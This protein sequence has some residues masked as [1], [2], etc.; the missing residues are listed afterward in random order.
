MVLCGI[1]LIKFGFWGEKMLTDDRHE[2]ICELVSKKGS[3][4]VTELTELYGVSDETVRRDLKRL[5]QSGK[6]RRVHG[7]AVARPGMKEFR[8]L[9]ARNDENST[10]KSELCKKAMSFIND[11]DIISV[12]SGSTA[13]ALAREIRGRFKNLKILTYSADVFNILHDDDGIEIYLAGG[14]YLRAEHCFC[15]MRT[16]EEIEKYHISKTFICISA[17]SMA[18]GIQDYVEEIAPMQK[19]LVENADRVFILADSSKIEKNAFFKICDAE[20]S[21]EYITDSAVDG[22]IAALYEENGYRLHGGMKK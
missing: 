16:V 17:V 21:F 20:K 2:R 4:T 12:D 15:G 5:E 3:V 22:A 19:A 9:S 13:A 7:G 1:I 6:L 10:L 14:K 8:A 18:C 11:G